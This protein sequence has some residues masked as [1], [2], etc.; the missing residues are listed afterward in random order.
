MNFNSNRNNN[1]MNRR[2]NQENNVNNIF[3][4]SSL[5][6]NDKKRDIFGSDS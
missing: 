1:L 3:G 6:F 5:N 4:Y 2:I